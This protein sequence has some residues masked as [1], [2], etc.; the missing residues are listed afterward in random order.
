M[1]FCLA[2]VVGLAFPT[3]SLPAEGK[4]IVVE[5][6]KT[7]NTELAVAHYAPTNRKGVG[8]IAIAAPARNSFAFDLA[9]WKEVMVLCARAASVKSDTMSVVGTMKE[10]DIEDVSQISISAGPGMYFV[11][12]SP[13]AGKVF[14]TVPPPEFSRLQ[15]GLFAVR[16]YL[17]QE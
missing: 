6:F 13:K 10:T 9:E 15:K 3:Y 12:T 14:Y 1:A 8:L 7:G 4:L 11:I 2:L 16:D 5:S 17:A